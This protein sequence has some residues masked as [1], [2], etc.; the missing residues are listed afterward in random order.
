MHT[1]ICTTGSVSL[2]APELMQVQY[3]PLLQGWLC[4]AQMMS[5]FCPFCIQIS[6]NILQK[7]ETSSL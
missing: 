2:E 5:A 1:G 7:E 6:D 4:T 3:H